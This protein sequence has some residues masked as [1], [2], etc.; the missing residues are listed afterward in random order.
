MKM[1]IEAEFYDDQDNLRTVTGYVDEGQTGM[2]YCGLQETPDDETEI[3]L[4]NESNLTVDEKDSA[5]EALW[6]EYKSI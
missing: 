3:V 2:S 5:L 1:E 6:V 4:A